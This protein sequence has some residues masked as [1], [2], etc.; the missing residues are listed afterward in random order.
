MKNFFLYLQCGII[1]LLLPGCLKVVDW[2]KDEVP[3]VDCCI[4]VDELM[5]KFMRTIQTYDQ[6][7]LVAKFNVLFLS[8]AV[9][10]YYVNR[11]VYR[12]GL[13]DAQKEIILKNEKEE[14]KHFIVFYVLSLYDVPLEANS[15]WSVLLNVNEQIYKFLEIKQV[16]LPREY[17][18]LFGKQYNRFKV[19]YKVRFDAQN[20]L[21]NDIIV[22]NTENI[23]LLL[24]S[25][26]C[27]VCASWDVQ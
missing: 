2:V 27:Q 7:N 6:F 4:D 9:R 11:Y 20:T 15:K 12:H 13:S 21:G 1:F 17:Y 5:C 8:S 26:D 24:R 18:C 10:E 23:Q 16:D 3:Q 19:A 22:D 25:L 14:E